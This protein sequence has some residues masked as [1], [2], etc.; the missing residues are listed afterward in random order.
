MPTLVS[1]GSLGFILT[2]TSLDLDYICEDP[3]YNKVTF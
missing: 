3:D 2:I 1:L